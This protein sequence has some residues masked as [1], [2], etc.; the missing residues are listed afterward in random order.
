MELQTVRP[1]VSNRVLAWSAILTPAI[2]V[3]GLAFH[4]DTVADDRAQLAIVAA[5]QGAWTGVHTLGFFVFAAYLIVV[6]ALAR[7]AGPG[8]LT[9][10]G[11]AL[12]ALGSAALV[13]INVL[14]LVL[15]KMVNVPDATGPMVDLLSRIKGPNLFVYPLEIALV[16]GLGLLAVLVSRARRLPGWAA[17]AVIL[18]G[19]LGFAGHP[20]ELPT[21]SLVG[22]VM[23]SAGLIWF[24]VLLLRS[25]QSDSTGVRAQP[26]RTGLEPASASSSGLT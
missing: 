23:R 8:R 12:S 25:S 9:V 22:E 19:L 13:G 18:G 21:L 14:E 16:V 15:V 17:G 3:L 24:G 20:A 1:L 6:V 4:P 10:L 7:V 26:Q 5:N 11:V 2:G